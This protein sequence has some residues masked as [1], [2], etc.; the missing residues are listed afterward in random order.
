MSRKSRSEITAAG[1]GEDRL[2]ALLTAGLPQ[3]ARTL[4]GPGD[5]CAVIQGPGKRYTLLKTDCIVEGVHF[6]READAARVG[7][8]ALCRVVS[9][10]AA[11]G[12]RPLEMLVT[13]AL[14]GAT[15][16]AWAEGLYAGM[17]KAAR[18]YGAGI[19]GGETTSLP[20]G[21]P[22]LISVAG[23]GE[24]SRRPVLR[25]TAMPGDVIC[26]TGR[27]GGSLAGWL[28]GSS[29][30]TIRQNPPPAPTLSPR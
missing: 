25:S 27:L 11:M 1:L 5:D 8:K 7:W 2:V 18:R 23:V 12:G 19:A 28:L 21:A 10:M 24:C 29:R 17:A 22:V 26:V 30:E 4:T 3:T 15:P 14:P 20:P 6:T 13:V 16:V 9:D